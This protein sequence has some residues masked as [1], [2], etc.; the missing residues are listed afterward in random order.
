M[1]H[2]L[3]NKQKQKTSTVTKH[4]SHKQVAEQN[5]HV[6]QLLAQHRIQP[7]LKISQPDDPLER[8]ADEMADRV[9][10]MTD[11]DIQKR[12]VHPRLKTNNASSNRVHRKEINPPDH[13]LNLENL[14]ARKNKFFGV[15]IRATSE[16]TELLQH[17]HRREGRVDHFYRDQKNLVTIGV[18]ILVKT[19]SSARRLANNPNYHFRW[20]NRAN[21]RRVLVSHVIRDWVNVNSGGRAKLK[22]ASESI[23]NLLV[24]G[25][26]GTFLDT[27]YRKRPYIK[28]LN[29]RVHMA[30]IDARFNPSGV[31][32]YGHSMKRFWNA[33]ELCDYDYAFR[34]F[35]ELWRNRGGAGNTRKARRLKRRYA[36]RHAWRVKQLK[37]GL[38]LSNCVP[39]RGL[40]GLYLDDQTYTESILSRKKNLQAKKGNYNIN[41]NFIADVNRLK[42]GGRSLH[43]NEKN[44]FE[45][46]FR[47]D[48]SNV[49]IHESKKANQLARN[50]RAQA[51][52]HKNHIILDNQPRN[53]YEDMK[54]VA[55]ELSHVLQQRAF[56]KDKIFRKEKLVSKVNEL[57]PIPITPKYIINDRKAF[58]RTCPPEL[59]PIRKSIIPQYTLLII[60][61]IIEK[62]VNGK[63]RKFVH[64]QEVV[65]GGHLLGW[66]QGWT[67]KANLTPLDT[68]TK[69]RLSSSKIRG[70]SISTQEFAN[71]VVRNATGE[72]N[73]EKWF[74]NFV[75]T[76]FMGRV[77]ATPIHLELAKLL[78][79]VE[80]KL[81]KKHGGKSKSSKVVGDMLGL[82]PSMETI[83]GSRKCATSAARSMHFF[84]L[85]IDLDYTRNPYIT[86]SKND[87]EALAK[88]LRRAGLIVK[89]TRTKF[90]KNMSIN[91]ILKID[92]ILEGYF[93]Y[94][95]DDHHGKLSERL[96]YARSNRLEYWNNKNINQAKIRI[97]KDLNWVSGVWMRTKA[98][99]KEG[100][101]TSFD[102]KL[103]E[104]L[105]SSG[106][107]WGGTYGDMMHFDM[108][109]KGTGKKIERERRK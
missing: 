96:I 10:G 36:T 106:L 34:R 27:L 86:E 75:Y 85:A 81:V 92:S 54:L 13:T 38:S 84:G 99:I 48:F 73:S 37:K 61:K 42:N 22:L 57:K 69:Y 102:K 103:I 24:A 70:K 46:R 11:A 63:D 47:A 60:N 29:P 72:E 49:K 65:P 4:S 23:D 21:R 95:D 104:E 56:V 101:F 51:F 91:D 3:V 98:I 32:I 80:A 40:F 58:M 18:G 2:V 41:N 71:E 100:G 5:D 55:H 44:Y 74:K 77:T 78:K 7:K 66:W 33:I 90:S 107:H 9:M 17:L 25:R 45:P 53:S 88:V 93:S 15:D 20:R 16:F 8:E 64:V 83:K 67:L 105:V 89:G 12:I 30:I 39:K 31:S 62:K 87:R 97:E 79:D 19:K 6:K 76:T 43:I 94:I 82:S 52:T 68:P 50:I 108:R 28:Y 14:K 109:N 35:K 1:N 26:L 59:K